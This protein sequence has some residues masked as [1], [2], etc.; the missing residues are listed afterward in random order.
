MPTVVFLQVSNAVVAFMFASTF[1]VIRLSYPDLRQ[2]SWFAALYFLGMLSP[3]AAIGELATGQTSL[4]G[5]IGHA[6]LLSA[7]AGMPVVLARLAERSVPWRS[8]A[9]CLVGGLIAKAATWGADHTN[10]LAEWADHGAFVAAMSLATYQAAMVARSTA[11]RLWSALAVA[12]FAGSVYFLPP[13]YHA[14][15]LSLPEDILGADHYGILVEAAASVLAISTGLI[16]LLIVMKEA[17]S[18]KSEEAETDTLT[19]LLNRRG[20]DRRAKAALA[21]AK[22]TGHLVKVIIFDL[23]RFKSINDTYGH[24]VGDKVLARFAEILD[25]NCPRLGIAARQ[26]G[27]EFVMLT[28]RTQIGDVWWVAERVRKELEQ[29]D[30]GIPTVTV[31][32]G[33]AAMQPGDTLEALMRRAD[34]W[35]YFAKNHGRNQVCPVPG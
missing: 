9:A 25:A 18:A 13:V 19:G 35:V 17:I 10:T 27:E 2:S 24:A 26:G 21:R 16:L 29:T 11:S 1:L 34:K 4:F 8:A 33:I 5:L 12:L 28:E 31:S 7:T 23:D 32:A 15:A 20:F 30:F 14:Q 6:G 3:L 22:H